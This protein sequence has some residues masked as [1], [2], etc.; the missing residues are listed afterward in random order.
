MMIL[1]Q[2]LEAKETYNS[3]TINI[4]VSFVAFGTPDTAEP[5]CVVCVK[6]LLRSHSLFTEP[7]EMMSRS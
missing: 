3:I 4:V 7:E 5:I 6:S 2:K 1:L